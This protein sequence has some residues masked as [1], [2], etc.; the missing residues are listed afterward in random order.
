[1][2]GLLMLA[3]LVILAIPVAVIYLLI[4]VSGLRSRIAELEGQLRQA[5]D[6]PPAARANDAKVEKDAVPDTP[7][8]QAKTT[9][10]P[11]LPPLAETAATRVIAQR[12][13]EAEAEN[14]ADGATPDT[15]APRTEPPEPTPLMRFGTWIVANWFYAVSALS[16]ALAGLFLVQ[17]GIEND[18]FPPTARVLAALGFGG[19]LISGGEVIRRRYG[20]GVDTA[21]AYIPSVFSGAGLVSLFG[22]IAA[23]RLLYELIGVEVAFAGMAAVGLLGVGLGWLYGPLLAAVGVVGAFVAPMFV[24][25]T[26]PP[27][28]WL[29]VY[30]GII[31][32]VGLGIDTIR[33]WAWVSILSVALGLVMGWLTVLGGE[34]D[35]S[36]GFQAYVAVL[37][38]LSILIPARSFQPDHGGVLVHVFLRGGNGEKP[39]FPTWL[40]LGAV[41]AA[42]ASIA[43]PA[44]SAS[45]QWSAAAG[46]EPFWMALVS[47]VI[48]SVA[49]IYWSVTAPALQDIAL[50]PVAAVLAIVAR[51]GG[52]MGPVWT[53]FADTYATNPEADF[54]WAVSMLWAV[55]LLLTGAM[56]MRALRPGEGLMSG[57]S[58]AL[59]APVMAIALEV[60]WRPALT[61]G[62]YPWALHA[63][64]LAAFMVSLAL[65]FARSDAPDRLR[66]SLFVLS[67]L[68]SI[69]FALVLILSLAALT[70]ALAMTVLVAAWLDRQFKLPLMQVF[71]A[72]GVAAVGVRL[73]GDPGLEWALDAPLWEMLLAYAGSLATFVAALVLLRGLERKTARIMLDTAG[74]STAGTT[75]SLLL[76]R[77][78][79]HVLPGSNTDT[80]WA[81]G[82]F[83]VIWLSLMLV[84]LLRIENLGGILAWVRAGLA[85]AFGLIGCGAL[86]LG[87]TVFSPLLSSWGGDVAGLPVLNTLIPAYLFPALLLG[88][89]AWRLRHRILRW[90]FGA[91]AVGLAVVWVFATIRHLW[92]GPASMEL[93]RSYLQPELYSYTVAILLTGAVLF[94]Q[95]LARNASGLRRA[96]LAVIGLAVAKV[97]LIDISGLDGL[98]RVLSLVVLGLSLAALAWLNRWAQTR[99]MQN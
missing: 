76:I 19:A 57:L 47:L 70:V 42:S 88:F 93:S 61:I 16:L 37:A 36:L 82:L 62:A 60:T 29:F 28:P 53:A 22:G 40:A 4:A 9:E 67:A 27:T 12:K 26:V 31:T 89:G 5:R 43:W 56:A 72:V 65:R 50:L 66:A 80:H 24:G 96:G 18:L 25:S 94:Y 21:T 6:V 79:D 81:M 11:P 95:S 35:L 46:T 71:I 14:A 13:A 49:L 52:E 38:V 2:E 23:A 63:I 85:L 77:F 68:A 51:E 74:W 90:G 98:V 41:A 87:L 54:P 20:D 8:E 58:A 91:A 78:L 92:Q 97:F 48:L 84:Q 45:I 64:V 34:V 86:G 55:G 30:F 33:R 10:A 73:V 44:A 3:G 69:T 99:H 59:T 1:M 39:A 75:V 32:A 17:Y 15:P 7:W 83:A